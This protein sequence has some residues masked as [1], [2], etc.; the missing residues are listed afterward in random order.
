MELRNFK[1]IAIN[2]EG[3]P[4]KGRIEALNRA[5]C[6]KYLRA[7]NYE[8]I[9]LTEY[10]SI[11]S[12]LDQISFG[13]IIKTKQLIFF[14]KQV[15]ALLNAGVKLLPTLELLALQQENRL[16]RKLFFELYQNV[17]NGFS[18]SIALSKRPKEF[19][20]L[21]VQMVEVGEMSGDLANTISKMA[22]YYDYQM[23][24]STQIKGAI[25]MP[26][27]YLFFAIVISIGMLLF[28][29]PNIT[30]LFASFEGAKL[31]AIT[32]FFIDTG[33]FMAHYALYI[34]GGL[35]LIVAFLYI[36]NKKNKAFHYFVSYLLLKLPIFGKLIRM[37]NQ[38]LMANSLAQMMSNGINSMKALNTVR[39]I[40]SNVV[41][42]NVISKTLIYI[43]DERPFSKAFEESNFIDP[44]MAHMISTGERTGDIPKLM[45]N[46]SSYY[47]GIT[48]LRV[49][50]L[51]NAIQPILLLLVY[52][53]VGMM[54]LALMLPML[55]LGGQI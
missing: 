34:F 35:F 23:K 24:I 54:I 26:V 2:A 51:K 41:Y 38:I 8:E 32:Q 55:S 10:K 17:Y 28:V 33:Q 46:L 27:I 53:I 52:A 3:K 12:K 45:E 20:N 30:D 22:D 31:P 14:L 25:R 18:F 1:Y 5:I 42:K 29:F 4:I 47:S 40:L 43:E 44:I 50:Q 36:L 16:L 39:N 9:R 7:K 15:G 13:S 19:P 21:L 48:E 11:L 6:L 37:N 49:E